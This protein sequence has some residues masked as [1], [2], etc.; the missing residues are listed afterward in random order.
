[1]ERF[2]TAVKWALNF[3]TLNSA[4]PAQGI[5]N[6]LVVSPCLQLALQEEFLIV[7]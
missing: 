7:L 4:L 6:R 1:M 3:I 2:V 5:S